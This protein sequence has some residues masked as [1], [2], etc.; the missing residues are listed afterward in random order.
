M[1]NNQ[2]II[3]L[4]Y[5]G[6]SPDHKGRKIEEIWQWDHDRLEYTHD[7]I[8][9][10]FPLLEKSRFNRDAPTLNLSIIE[11]FKNTKELKQRLHQSLLLMLDFYGLKLECQP[12]QTI[13]IIPSETYPTRKKQWVGWRDHNYLRLTRILTSLRLLGLETQAKA[14]FQ[15]LDQIYQEEQDKIGLETYMYWKNALRS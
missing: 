14:L 6:L 8:Q 3:I 13:Q 1:A 5:L 11:T 9:W 4:F 2:D 7:Y 10:L 15:C 12:S